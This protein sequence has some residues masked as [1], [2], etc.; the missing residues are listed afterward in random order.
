MAIVCR[1]LSLAH[2]RSV[3]NVKL[4]LIAEELFAMVPATTNDAF[5]LV[6][7]VNFVPLDTSA[8]SLIPE[9]PNTVS[10]K[11]ELAKSPVSSMITAPKNRSARLVFAQVKV[12]KNKETYA[13]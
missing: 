10:Q 1:A 7:P 3:K 4:M 8:D 2:P 6:V 12:L 9:C 5:N 11:V 13:V